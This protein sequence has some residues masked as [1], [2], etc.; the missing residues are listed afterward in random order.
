MSKAVNPGASAKRILVIKLSALGD[1]VLA[2]GAMRVIREFHPD[3]HIALLTTLPY[4]DFARASGLFDR[5]QTNGRPETGKE[6]RAL[7]KS[8]RKEQYE[9]VYDLHTSG[10]TRNYFRALNFGFGP[11]PLWSGHAKGSAFFHS[12]PAR[13]GMHSIDRLADQLEVAGMVFWCRAPLRTAMQSA[14]RMN[15]TLILPA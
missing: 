4:Q 14:G 11:K 10:R 2:M 13:E 3:A 1:F 7:L 6:T 5:I 8:L 9:V 15:A 12:N